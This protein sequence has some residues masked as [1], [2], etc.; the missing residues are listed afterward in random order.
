MNDNE[1]IHT[2]VIVQYQIH[3]ASHCN[4]LLP[5]TRLLGNNM[6]NTAIA[7]RWSYNHFVCY[8]VKF[9]NKEFADALSPLL[10]LT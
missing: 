6:N 4:E 7:P 3:R 10:N 1:V 8:F 2:I 5:C 9:I